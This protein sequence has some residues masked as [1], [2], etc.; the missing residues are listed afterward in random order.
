MIEMRWVLRPVPLGKYYD[1][2]RM[3][4]ELQYRIAGNGF[5]C[6]DEAGNPHCVETTRWS[7]WMDVPQMGDERD[8]IEKE[9]CRKLTELAQEAGEY[10]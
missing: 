8:L 6:V 5:L 4:R 9:A 3:R 7:A 10:D 1:I 2:A